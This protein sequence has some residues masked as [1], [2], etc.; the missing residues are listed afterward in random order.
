MAK[1][2]LLF[3]LTTL[4]CKAQAQEEEINFIKVNVGGTEL[5]EKGFLADES[6]FYADSTGQTHSYEDPSAPVVPIPWGEVYRTHRYAIG[7]S[8]SYKFPV[9]DGVFAVGLMFVEQYADIAGGDRI[10]DLYINDVL[11]DEDIDVWTLAGKKL[12]EPYYLKKLDITPVD[13]HILITLVPKKENPMLS[14]IVI[15]GPNAASVLWETTAP[16]IV[17]DSD[18]A[19]NPN[20]IATPTPVAVAEP[21]KAESEIEEPVVQ[22]ES[23]MTTI[24]TPPMAMSG[25][26]VWGNV[27]YT[28]GNPVARHEAC[29]VFGDGLVYSI[30][31]RGMKPVS[32]F[33]PVTGEWS[34]KTGPPVEIN[35]MQC[36]YYKNRIYIGGS[37][38]GQFPYEKEHTV[39]WAYD[40]PTDTWLTLKGL[41]EGRR[42]GGGAF[43]VYKEKFYLSHGAIG[44]HGA[45]ATTTGYLDMY[46]PVT[47]EWIPLPDGPGPRD[48][49]AGAVVNDKL[50]VAGGR[51]GGVADFWNANVAPVVCYTFATKKWEVRASLPVPR[52]GSMVGATCSGLIMIAGGEGKTRENQKG[53]AFDRVDFYDDST[54]SFLEPSYMTSRRHG[55][56]LAISSCDCGSIYVPSG[57]AGLGGGPEVT[58]T[59]MWSPDGTGRMCV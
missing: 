4:L 32:V 50:C 38:F 29:A 54:N 27:Q 17:T 48:H 6:Y 3:A 1:L 13:G 51:D 43:V 23:E 37:W 59:D 7:G 28:S 5:Y 31:G 44:G 16:S 10:F 55:S 58:T 20:P 52:G 30:G 11:L 19:S 57:S 47:N 46:D 15:E 2:V 8:L 26:G 33:N 45:H 22:S 21:M 36:V 14:G 34:R 42:R 35:H 12:Y 9:P 53:Q 18:T 40:I 39:M 24:D 49:T 25:P 41:P 56:G